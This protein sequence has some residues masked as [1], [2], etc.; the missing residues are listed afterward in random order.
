[1]EQPVGGK[2][3]DLNP[4]VGSALA[5]DQQGWFRN[6]NRINCLEIASLNEIS[7]EATHH[8]ET[9]VKDGH[10]EVGARLQHVGHLSELPFEIPQSE[11]IT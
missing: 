8:H 7:P 1:M 2:A 4:V 11:V 9:V 5:P 6:V 3:V 10:R